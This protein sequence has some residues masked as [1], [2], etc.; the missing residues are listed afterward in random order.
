MPPREFAPPELAEVIKHS[1]ILDHDFFVWLE[2][3]IDEVVALDAA[4]LGLIVRRNCE[5]K[6][7]I[8]AEDE[9]ERGRR[10][11]FNLGHTFGHALESLGG[12][13]HWLH[14][15]AVS[16]GICPRPRGPPQDSAG[17]T[18]GTAIESNH[19]WYA[20]GYRSARTDVGAEPLLERMRMDKK[21]SR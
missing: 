16:I 2:E 5:L 7:A 11:L 15:E 10:A 17:S 6:A 1:L 14:G 9:H 18:L 8:V 4:A 13:G 21:A 12:Y 19:C 20:P 3:H